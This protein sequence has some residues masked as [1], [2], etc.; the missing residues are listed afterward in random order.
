[1]ILKAN[2]SPPYSVILVMDCASG[3]I[4]ETLNHR[5]IAATSSCVAV[6]TLAETDGETTIVLTNEIGYPNS[7]EQL[8]LK[9]SGK[10]AA[11][12]KK[13]DICTAHLTVIVS[14]DLTFEMADV[15]VWANDDC[16]PDRICIVVK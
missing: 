7:D 13:L 16:E 5:L 14:I 1:M 6:G 15:Q 8:F 3:E 9:F 10:V 2:I 4:P 11:P 12:G